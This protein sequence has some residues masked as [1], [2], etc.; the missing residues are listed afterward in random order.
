[1]LRNFGLASCL[2]LILLFIGYFALILFSA[3]WY[4]DLNGIRGHETNTIY[5][6]IFFGGGQ[7]LSLI[8]SF[9]TVQL[10]RGIAIYMKRKK[11][12]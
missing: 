6:P 3:E 1:M 8:L 10:L 12:R 7:L 4:M 2:G 11:E 5:M 9:V